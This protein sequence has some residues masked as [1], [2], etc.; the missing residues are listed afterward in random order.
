MTGK[1]P[2]AKKLRFLS[3][4]GQGFD[5]L[6]LMPVLVLTIISLLV[7]FSI[8]LPHGYQSVGFNPWRQLVFVAIGLLSCLI[9]VRID[10]RYLR[11]YAPWIY[12][13]SLVL[14]IVTLVVGD[15]AGGAQ[16]WISIASVRFQPSELAKFGLIL[17]LARMFSRRASSGKS[18]QLLAVTGMYAMLP[19][20]M[21]FMQP[22]LSTGIVC[23]AIWLSMA[24][25]SPVK[26]YLLFATAGAMLLAALVSVPLL[27]D[28][29]R[30]RLLSFIQPSQDSQGIGYSSQ[31]S[32]ITVGS[33]GLWGQGLSG[34]SQSQLLFLPEQHTD[35]IFAVIAEKLG[36]I[37]VITVLA[38]SSILI[39]RMIWYVG[40]VKDRFGSYV[41]AGVASVLAIHL[42][43]NV[44]MNL[45]LLPVTGLPLPFVS[46]GGTHIIV[47]FVMVGVVMSIVT[48][49][50][51]LSFS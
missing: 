33:G 5:W 16:R 45:G 23:I 24:M 43:V 13:G 51:S 28:Y 36:F 22:D 12:F 20:V 32:Q 14:L 17:L 37:G 41:I 4:K 31:Q 39:L 18:V 50:R 26:K 44:G 9:L 30:D 40:R 34:G 46:Y 1:Y 8:K 3:G 10:Y 49:Q 7:L 47:S 21:I 48:R 6:L 11:R 27:A 29:Q 35:F 38:A 2:I 42:V 15:T 19:T 25:C